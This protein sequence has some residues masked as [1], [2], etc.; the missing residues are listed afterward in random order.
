MNFYVY[1]GDLANIYNIRNETE[2]NVKRFIN[3]IKITMINLL[4]VNKN[5]IFNEKNNTF[6]KKKKWGRRVTLFCGFA[7]PFNV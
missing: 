2:K 7:T 3:L 1:E 6:Q 5:N 4:H